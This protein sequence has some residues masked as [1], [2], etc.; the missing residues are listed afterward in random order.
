MRLAVAK[1]DPHDEVDC[2]FCGDD[3][4]AQMANWTVV[5]FEDDGVVL[6]LCAEHLDALVTVALAKH[7]KA[8]EQKD[9][10]WYLSPDE[11]PW[12]EEGKS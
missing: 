8:M 3:P 6:A 5:V 4:R 7:K 1:Y 10:Y 2:P 11:D 12:A 9:P